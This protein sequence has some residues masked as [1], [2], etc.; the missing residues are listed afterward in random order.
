MNVSE[1]LKENAN[2]YNKLME[3]LEYLYMIDELNDLTN[4]MNKTVS[5]P[6]YMYYNDGYGYGEG[7]GYIF[8]A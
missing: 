5:I 3:L 8:L 1:L 7:F 2:D 6:Y 4:G